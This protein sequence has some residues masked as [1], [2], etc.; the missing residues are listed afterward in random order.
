MSMFNP[1]HNLQGPNDGDGND[2]PGADDTDRGDQL[3]LDLELDVDLD[4]EDLFGEETEEEK[5]E[6]LAAEAK[7]EREKNIRIP[8]HRFDE[9][10]GAA[11]TRA[12]RA[13][14]EAEELRAQLAERAAPAAKTDAPPPLAEVANYIT[15][16]EDQYEDAVIDGEKE[17]AKAIREKLNRARDY[18]TQRRI[19]EATTT[20]RDQTLGSIK[21]ETALAQIEAAYPALNP[22]DP[23]YDADVTAEV[24]ELAK[25]FMKAGQSNTQALQRA[26]QLL[27]RDPVA[28]A[29]PAK[30]ARRVIEPPAGLPGQPR[31]TAQSGRTAAP[32]GIRIENLSQDAF[33]K[34]D[35]R[36]LSK[37]R[38]DT[39]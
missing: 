1:K 37:A 34:I 18:M 26:T 5:E 39:L 25:T 19:D 21:Y 12:E 2:L 22:N 16:L 35:E 23:A 32:G 30:P 20:T 8:K 28:P 7:A 27:L 4:D 11:R 10:V 14:Q 29:A 31:S 6:R 17:E 36:T 3:E 24:A 33:A 9:E 13:E 38:G 15:Q